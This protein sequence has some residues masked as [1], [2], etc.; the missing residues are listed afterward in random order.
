MFKELLI[1]QYN[2]LIERNW[3]TLYFIV[4]V[5]EVILKPNY[6]KLAD[7]Y[8][9]LSKETLQMLSN[10]PE[11]CLVMWTASKK[12]DRKK[13]LDFFRNDGILFKYCNENP[14]IPEITSWGDYRTKMYANVG[15]DDKF[16]FSPEKH[17][18]QIYNFY[19][20]LDA[21]ESQIK[22]KF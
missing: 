6:T 21:E 16:G 14:E 2:R 10:R 7:E 19:I 20:D 22:F 9:P 12:E 13:Y 8:Y 15:L 1:K 11:V 17:W 4:D 18:E 5:H 3:D